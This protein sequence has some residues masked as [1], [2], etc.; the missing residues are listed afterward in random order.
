MTK[1]TALSAS[2]LATTI[3]RVDRTRV[4]RM[5][6]WA[7]LAA[8]FAIAA[9]ML[10]SMANPAFAQTLKQTGVN[11]FNMLYGIV[12][13]VGA[14][15]SVVTL[16]NWQTGNWFGRDDPKRLFMQVLAATALAF[17]V[18]AIIQ[19]LKESVGGSASGVSNL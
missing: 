15:A 18:V 8:R 4:L 16:L 13:V 1:L 3:T 6:D 5:A 2:K 17:A 7:Q 9:L 14:I 12:G 19:F 11:I 10:A